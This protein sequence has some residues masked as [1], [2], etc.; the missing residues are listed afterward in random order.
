M[1]NLIRR[2]LFVFLGVFIM[3]TL[4]FAQDKGNFNTTP[5]TNN[6]QKWRIGYYEGGEYKEYQEMLIAIVKALMRA[7]WIETMPIP[8]QNGAQT[9]ELWKW[10]ATNIK[11]EY[12][13]F[14]ENAHYSAEWK[15]D[16]RKNMVTVILDRLNQQRDI[17]LMIASGT[18]AGQDL[19]TDQHHTPTIV[20]ASND[21]VGAGIVKSLEDSGY[22]YVHA[23]VDPDRY[24]RQV[25]IFYDIIGFPTLGV[26][27]EDSPVGRTYAAIETIN[28]V[29][30]ANNFQVISCNIQ[31]AE[32][33]EQNSA[34]EHAIACFREL[35]EKGVKAV[36]VTQQVGVNA[37]TIPQL[38]EIFNA[39]KIPSFSQAS[40]E[41]EVQS[42]ILLSISLAE[43]QYVA[44]FETGVIAKIFNG[45]KP[46]EISQLFQDPPKIAINLKT[47]EIIGYDP[48]VD[49]LGAADE[50]YQDIVAPQ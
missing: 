5:T 32:N 19:A 20:V 31:L 24:E 23:R 21:P 26:T 11:S 41:Q 6:G 33:S 17:D 7:G 1:M 2:V 30:Q 35:A 10:L 14:A 29:A 40:S 44:D 15:E 12:L 49:V 9:A 37:K 27:Y 36:Y 48:P 16:V 39:H 18:W 25:Q 13:Q 34:N 3:N 45:A 46:R 28:K 8:E 4:A 50:I 43:F 22:D 42:G 47:A 38:V